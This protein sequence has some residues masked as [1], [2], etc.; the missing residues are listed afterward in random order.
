LGK[1]NRNDYSASSR[2]KANPAPASWFDGN[3][4]ELSWW[5]ELKSTQN[6][7]IL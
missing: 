5:K 7:P 2:H 1:L 3:D 4:D 6:V